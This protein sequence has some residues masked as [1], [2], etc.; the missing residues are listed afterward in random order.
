MGREPLRCPGCRAQLS[1]PVCSRCGA[2]FSK[3][4]EAKRAAFAHFLR[5]IRKLARNDLSGAGPELVRAQS[6]DGSLPAL[7]ELLALSRRPPKN[8]L[9]LRRGGEAKDGRPSWYL[10]E[11]E[12][13]R[14]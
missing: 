11:S 1:S 4:E 3:V 5:G 14:R 7:A 9:R 12:N 8:P 13:R 6:L 2:D 10:R